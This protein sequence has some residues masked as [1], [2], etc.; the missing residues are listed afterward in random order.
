MAIAEADIIK[1]KKHKHRKHHYKI[2]ITYT[3][4]QLKDNIVRFLIRVASPDLPRLL[5]A[6]I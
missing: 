5:I 6:Q 3:L 4:S 2:N 1:D